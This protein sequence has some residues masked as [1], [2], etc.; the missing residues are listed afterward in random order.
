MLY[1][2][3]IFIYDLVLS[4]ILFFYINRKS[5]GMFSTKLNCKWS[6]SEGAL[7]VVAD[8]S[9]T[10]GR[11]H[12]LW[13]RPVWGLEESFDSVSSSLEWGEVQAY[14]RKLL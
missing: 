5:S 1:M 9:T 8:R 13:S 10:G 6:M 12:R 3:N 11:E 14:L 7:W 2:E 4:H